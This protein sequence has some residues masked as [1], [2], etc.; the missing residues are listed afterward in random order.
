MSSLTLAGL[1]LLSLGS[2]EPTF[3]QTAEP[4]AAFTDT[5]ELPGT[6]ETRNKAPLN[7]AA[8][9]GSLTR[10]RRFDGT[11]WYQRTVEI[12]AA[13]AGK[14]IQLHLER[15]KY[16]QVWLDRSPLGEQGLYGTPQ[17][18]DLTA[19]ATPGSHTLTI[20]VDNRA[21]RRPVQAEAHQF[22]DNTQTNWN[23]LLGR[24][25]LTATDPGWLDDVQAY[26]DVAARSFRLRLR[27]G[28]TLDLPPAGTLTVEAES[29][30]H[31]GTPSRATAT[32]DF[33]GATAELE[34]P[35]GAEARLWDEFSPALYRLRIRLAAG[36]YADERTVE[37]GL[38]EFRTKDRQFT[39]N[40]RPT[41]LRGKHDACVFPLTGHPPMDVAGWTA[42]LAKIKEWGFNH[43]RC[44]TWIPPE[45][46]FTAADR[47]GLYLQPELPFWGTFEAKV[48]DFLQPE[49][50][51]LLRACGNHPSFVMLT[52][53]NEIGGDRA[54]M[55]ALVTHLRSLDPRHLYADG[56]NNVLWDPVFQPTNDFMASAKIRPPAD[57]SRQLVGRGSFCVFDGNEGHT[58]WGPSETRTDLSAAF[59]GLPVPY[60]GHET[61]QW[62]VYPS[63]REIAKYTGVTRPRNLERF[64]ASL[65]HRGLLDQA[66]AFQRASGALAAEL[67][68]EENELFLRSPGAGGFQ[69]LDLQDFPGQGTALV[70]LL[71]AFMDSKGLVTPAEFRRSCA[72]HVLLAR[73]DRYVWTTGET[74]TADL[75]LAHYGPTDLQSVATLWA[76]K[77][78]DGR[79]LAEG[80]FPAADFACGGLRSLGTVNVPLSAIA[81][82]ARLDLVVTLGTVAEQRWSVWVYPAQIDTAPPPG[83]TLARRYD[84]ATEQILIAGGRVVLMPDSPNW[85]D[86][87]P[88]GYATDYWCWPMFNGTPGTMGLL[89]QPEHPAL[90]RFPTRFHSERQWADLA[91]ASTPVILDATPAALRPLVQVIDN[92]ERNEKLGLVF[93]A[94]VGAGR[95]LVC[96]VDL[97]GP[98]LQASPAARQLLASLLAYA[99]SE[100]FAPSV[101]L[102][103]ARAATLF[104]PS[105]A[106]AMPATASSSFTPPWGFVPKPLHAFDGDNN[107]RW[108]AAADDK[109]PWL[110]IDLGVPRSFGTVELLWTEDT[111]GYRYLLE[112][113]ADGVT[114]AP[115]SDQR[116][117]NVAA[118]RH[119]CPVQANGVRYLRVAITGTPTGK[120]AALRELRVLER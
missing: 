10:I 3:P 72:P 85:A 5:I 46:A 113:S 116:E 77:T 28:S 11:A 105:L 108:Q 118:G 13:W 90:A 112:G 22:S 100:A 7:D 25:E 34:L 107:T 99:G 36:A 93:E 31:D 49:A 71:D 47:L 95:L 38:R 19:R 50:E 52:L 82:P 15:T 33:R 18:Y 29:F 103:P 24:L 6:T 1:W 9:T 4:P 40:G 73:F 39:I 89:I 119:F 53:G 86:T 106:Y 60:I 51:S 37:T 32:A 8:E 59:A 87:L 43:V 61:G 57:P 80:A 12:P 48:R 102:A 101:A 41:F 69:H 75:Q 45:A 35:L 97:L 84:A 30:N 21:A 83:V 70:G 55:N 111:A 78:P 17:T 92:Y 14:R 26:P 98:K 20:L 68:R 62:T 115:L 96:A 2:P 74:Y 114:W 54:L 81:A 65:E 16:T 23:G 67:Y 94:R 42:Y 79:T 109:S 27:I 117:N 66:D 44:H 76:L 91:H 120:P 110:A 88:G 104:A 64:R 58:Q 56:S 63:F